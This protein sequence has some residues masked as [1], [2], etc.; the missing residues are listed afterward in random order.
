MKTRPEKYIIRAAE[1]L[2]ERFREYYGIF[3]PEPYVRSG[4]IFQRNAQSECGLGEAVLMFPFAWGEDM[5]ALCTYSSRTRQDPS[6]RWPYS[7][8][9][10]EVFD[11]LRNR[12]DLT[13]RSSKYR[14]AGRPLM[15][16]GRYAG[17]YEEINTRIHGMADLER[18]LRDF[19]DF[20]YIV[21]S[22]R[23]R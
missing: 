19:Q 13:S 14:M 11:S 16:L 10:I 3:I 20:P 18:V 6:A 17:F 8:D 23:N 5:R 9:V 2:A 1:A 21:P 22:R 4:V 7:Q 15:S 12:L